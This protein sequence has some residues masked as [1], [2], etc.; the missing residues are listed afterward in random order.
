MDIAVDSIVVA[1]VD[2]IVT[3]DTFAPE[4]PDGPAEPN[5]EPGTCN[6]V[7]VVTDG[8]VVDVTG[9]SAIV[10]AK[11]EEVVDKV[12]EVSGGCVHNP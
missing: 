8:T 1:V 6:R 7:V 3:V 10:G 12:V 11:V 4:P 2:D 5:V 9:E